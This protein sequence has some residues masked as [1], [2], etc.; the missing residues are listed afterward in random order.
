MD[1]GVKVEGRLI[2][3]SPFTKKQHTSILDSHN[4]Q[5]KKAFKRST[6]II[7]HQP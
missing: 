2:T 6:T 7:H 3:P 1:N 4:F 5:L